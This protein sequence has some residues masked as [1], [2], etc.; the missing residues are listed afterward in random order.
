M[1]VSIDRRS[2]LRGAAAGAAALPLAAM[3]DGAN[4][5]ATAERARQMYGARAAGLEV[6]DSR[7]A[8]GVF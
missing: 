4:S 7:A 1:P 2:V 6:R 5:K 8:R 3:A